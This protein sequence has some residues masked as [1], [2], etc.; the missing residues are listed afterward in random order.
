MVNRN[1]RLIVID[2]FKTKKNVYAYFLATYMAVLHE[3]IHW[4]VLISGFV[5]CDAGAGESPVIPENI[6]AASVI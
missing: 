2:T 6:L 1:L 3:H 4:L 5:L